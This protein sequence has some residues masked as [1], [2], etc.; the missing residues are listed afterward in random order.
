MLED[1]SGR[2]KLV[3]DQ[4]KS[5]RLVTGIIIGALGIETNSGDFEVV[6]ICFPGMAPQP[7]RSG[8]G[9]KHKGAVGIDG[10]VTVDSVVTPLIYLPSFDSVTA[11]RFIRLG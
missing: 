2:I 11:F 8:I 1:E 10:N 9:S 7:S 4:L 3:G 6:D 5:I